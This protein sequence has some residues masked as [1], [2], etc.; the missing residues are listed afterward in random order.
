ML[1]IIE[2]KT[3]IEIDLYFVFSDVYLGYIFILIFSSR[4]AE[5]SEDLNLKQ[6]P[7]RLYKFQV[8]AVI[9]MTEE[10][11]TKKFIRKIFSVQK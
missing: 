3:V 1:L 6:T 7:S 11:F 5:D 10:L 9:S 2:L 8:L 4:K